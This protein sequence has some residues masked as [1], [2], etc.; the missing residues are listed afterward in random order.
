MSEAVCRLQTDEIE[1][2]VNIVLKKITSY[3]VNPHGINET[4]GLPVDAVVWVRVGNVTHNR[5]VPY[6]LALEIEEDI[7]EAIHLAYES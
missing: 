6:D 3:G 2:S 5:F 7:T 1:G 4:T